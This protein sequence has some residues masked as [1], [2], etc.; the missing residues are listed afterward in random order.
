VGFQQNFSENRGKML[1]LACDF[2]LKDVNCVAAS[3][4]VF[5]YATEYQHLPN[6]NAMYRVPPKW[7]G[8]ACDH[9]TIPRFG[10]YIENVEVI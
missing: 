4:S 6:V 5:G 10:L 9:E 2:P 1:C 8:G 3:F 7:T